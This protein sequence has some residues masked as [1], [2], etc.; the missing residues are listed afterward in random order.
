M[1]YIIHTVSE[2]FNWAFYLSYW[3]FDQ[4][5]NFYLGFLW[6]FCLLTEL[7]FHFHN[8]LPYFIHM[9]AC[10]FLEFIQK[11]I[12]VLFNFIQEFIC[13]LFE[14]F[15][16]FINDLLSWVLL[17]FLSLTAIT[18]GLIYFF[19]W[20]HIVLVF[21][22]LLLNVGTCAVGASLF[23]QVLVLLSGQSAWSGLWD[24]CLWL[25]WP[26]RFSIG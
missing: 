5:H 6:Y 26:I 8:W 21:H 4:Q 3:D 7:Y 1:F 12:P 23:V 20:R 25:S 19:W 17:R 24:L 10:V 2:I 18:M 14:F 15:E 22:I 9:F 13:I 11:C 16:I